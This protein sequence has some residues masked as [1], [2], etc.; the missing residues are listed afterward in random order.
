MRAADDDN[1]KKLMGL[2]K[3]NIDPNEDIWNQYYIAFFSNTALLGG[4]AADGKLN[5]Y[6]E[7]G[8]SGMRRLIREMRDQP[9]VELFNFL[10]KNKDFFES[11]PEQFPYNAI[12]IGVANKA[13]S[14]DSDAV[15]VVN[16]LS[17]LV[18]HLAGNNYFPFESIVLR[19]PSLDSENMSEVFTTIKN[20][21]ASLKN[22]PS[23]KKIKIAF[24][25][26]CRSHELTAAQY[27]EI[28]KII[29]ENN[30]ILSF[31]FLGIENTEQDAR[32]ERENARHVLLN[33]CSTNIRN[34]NIARRLA[35][36]NNQV[37]TEKKSKHG[38]NIAFLTSNSAGEIRAVKLGNA[39]K[40][41][42][43]DISTQA[44]Q[45]HQMQTQLQQE[46]QQ[47]TQ[48]QAQKQNEISADTGVDIAELV[49]RQRYIKFSERGPGSRFNELHMAKTFQCKKIDAGILG[50]VYGTAHYFSTLWGYITGNSGLENSF[51]YLTQ[52]AISKIH[53]MPQYF[54]GGLNFD[55]LPAGFFAQQ[56]NDGK[57][58]L[59][60][61]ATRNSEN[62]NKSPLTPEIKSRPQPEPWVGDWRQFSPAET[63]SEVYQNFNGLTDKNGTP[64]T[65]NMTKAKLYEMMDALNSTLSAEIK[66]N[67]AWVLD[68]RENR[69]DYRLSAW[70]DIVYRE[71]CEGLGS[72]LTVLK[73][74][75]EKNKD[76]ADDFIRAF[77]EFNLDYGDS[78]SGNFVADLITPENLALIEKLADLTDVQYR[79]WKQIVKCQS[80]AVG[81]LDFASL[82]KGFTYF[83]AQIPESV[84]LPYDCPIEGASPLVQLDRLLGILGKVNAHNL[85]YQ[86]DD[87][88]VRVVSIEQKNKLIIKIDKLKLSI[89]GFR[90]SQNSMFSMI[91]KSKLDIKHELIRELKLIR[92]LTENTPESE[93]ADSIDGLIESLK[94][95]STIIT[96]VVIGSIENT[97]NDLRVELGG[98]SIQSSLNLGPEG[99]WYAARWDNY[100]YFHPEMKLNAD[101]G[102]INFQVSYDN[103]REL[104]RS[105]E[106]SFSDIKTAFY[107]YIGQSD[108]I[109]MP[110]QKYID[111]TKTLNKLDLPLKFK[112]QLL[113]CLAIATTGPRGSK[114]FDPSVFFEFILKNMSESM[115]YSVNAIYKI[116][117]NLSERPTVN[118]LMALIK[119][120]SSFSNLSEIEN[121]VKCLSDAPISEK[122]LQ[123]WDLWQQNDNHFP[124]DSFVSLYSALKQFD[125]KQFDQL[126]R[127][128]AILK[129]S[130]DSKKIN[131]LTAELEKHKTK[132]YYEPL[133]KLIASLDIEKT[134]KD[135]LPT[136]D[137]LIGLL[138]SATNQNIETP[139]DLFQFVTAKLT[140]C[141]FDRASNDVEPLDGALLREHIAAFNTKLAEY[142]IPPISEEE[143]EKDG[144]TY[145]STLYVNLM[146]T[147]QRKMPIQFARNLA[148]SAIN[149]KALPAFTALFLA[150]LQI[151]T[152]QFS[153]LNKLKNIFPQ[154]AS[155][156][157]KPESMLD[158]LTAFQN[159]TASLEG[160]FST[161]ADLKKKWGEKFTLNRVINS[162]IQYP[163]KQLAEIFTALSKVNYDYIPTKLFNSIFPDKTVLPENT[164]LAE[165]ASHIEKIIVLDGLSIYQKSSLIDQVYKNPMNAN[166]IGDIVTCLQVLKEKNPEIQT[167]FFDT[168]LTVLS[169]DNAKDTVENTKSLLALFTEKNDP[170]ISI[171]FN[172]L[173]RSID[174][175]KTL[176]AALAEYTDAQMKFLKIMAYSFLR[177]ND[178]LKQETKEAYDDLIKKLKNLYDLTL[179]HARFINI[180]ALYDKIPRPGYHSLLKLIESEDFLENYELDPSGARL[181]PKNVAAQFNIDRIHERIDAIEDLGRDKKEGNA[182]ALFHNEREKLYDAIGYVTA[183]GKDS[184]ITIPGEL[185][186]KKNYQKPVMTLTGDEIKTL[187]KHYRSIISANHLTPKEI[188]TA[189]CEF[190]AL[191]REALYRTTGIMAYDTQIT[192]ILNIMLHGGSIFSEIRTGEGKSI[193]TA[194]MAAAKWAEGGVVDVASSNMALAKRDLEENKDF[195]DYLGIQTAVISASSS[196]SDY[197]QAGTKDREGNDN[198][199]GINYSDISEL[200]LWQEQQLLNSEKLPDKVSLI[201]DEVDFNVLDNTTQFR[202]AT[203]L[204]EAYDP[205]FN[206]YEKIY[207]AV[208]AFV[209]RKDLFL[210]QA[211]SAKQDI[212]NLKKY[213]LSEQCDL[214][215]PLKSKLVGIPELILD[216]WIN[217]AYVAT[218]LI[219]DEDYVIRQGKI[220]KNGEEVE[221]SEAQVRINGRANPQSRFSDGVQQFLNTLLNEKMK[222]DSSFSE[223]CKHNPFVIEPE[224]TYLASRSA[225]NT[226]DYYLRPDDKGKKRGDVVGLTGTLGT[227]KDRVELFKNYGVKFFRMPPHKTLRRVPMP[228]IVAKVGFGTTNTTE[229]MRMAHFNSIYSDIQRAQ[230]K[231]QCILIVCD[232]VEF[233]DA[234]HKFLQEKKL[235]KQKLQLHNGEQINQDE[236]TVT[237]N[238]AKS[239]M[240]TIS[241]LM[242]GRGTD[243]K[244]ENEN[245]LHVITTYISGEREYGQ[246]IGRAG[247]NGAKGSDQLIVSASEFTSRVKEIPSG[248]KKI[249]AE[250]KVIRDEI[251]KEKTAD[252]FERQLYSDVK[253]QF[254]KQYTD[255]SAEL[256]TKTNNPDD[257]KVAS[258]KSHI[259]WEAFLKSIDQ[260][261]NELLMG[262]RNEVRVE[263]AARQSTINGNMELSKTLRRHQLDALPKEMEAYEKT[264]LLEKIKA[265]TEFGNENWAPTVDDIIA[266]SNEKPVKIGVNGEIQTSS[267]SD[268]DTDLPLADGALTSSV[269]PVKAVLSDMTVIAQPLNM[270][271]SADTLAAPL[272]PS[273]DHPKACYSKF[274]GSLS[275]NVAK[276]DMKAGFKAF[277][278][279]LFQLKFPKNEMGGS[280][281]SF[282][283][284]LNY[285]AKLIVDDYANTKTF[286]KASDRQIAADELRVGINV[287]LNDNTDMTDENKLSALILLL[288]DTTKSLATSD[289]AADKSSFF[290]YR[291]QSGSRLQTAIDKVMSF[292]LS[293]KIDAFTLQD[294]HSN[295]IKALLKT[296]NSRLRML[297]MQ[298]NYALPLKPSMDD[299]RIMRDRLEK[300]IAY[301]EKYKGNQFWSDQIGACLHLMNST[302]KQVSMLCFAHDMGITDPVKREELN[303]QHA[304]QENAQLLASPIGKDFLDRHAV[305]VTKRAYEKITGFP[306]GITDQQKLLLQKTLLEIERMMT[307]KEGSMDFEFDKISSADSGKNITVIARFTEGGINKAL[308]IGIDNL[309]PGSEQVVCTA[310]KIFDGLTPNVRC[311]N[312]P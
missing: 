292:A 180:A 48:I 222:K 93:N 26:G 83:L 19:T 175:Y 196:N 27:N 40:L 288:Q 32:I 72:I 9:L 172:T 273:L 143:F 149:Q 59:C 299:L 7:A 16:S 109:A 308:R 53:A 267:S 202:Y 232:T 173:S 12:I 174:G 191:L 257:W 254:F 122:I 135:N 275:A 141:V 39:K 80:D 138:A 65:K 171:I 99:A 121:A 188:W 251:D 28:A 167:I 213:I 127:I 140:G 100:H 2:L 148:I 270:V 88:T 183:I 219:P 4:S 165:L 298:A 142:K 256:K 215:D 282:R 194:M 49:D 63:N 242:F 17:V 158:E 305:D 214:A 203:S 280:L 85:K 177:Q 89:S 61:D 82:Y 46:T 119:I 52:S 24:Q 198:D 212:I 249:N 224:K 108:C 221:T 193:I 268:S 11:Y 241:T 1:I 117:G 106:N 124:A 29:S 74:L 301:I 187:V 111:L 238:A 118:E 294:S 155:I 178:F 21:I 50:V 248:F 114:A 266:H 3:I 71:G 56:H 192:S 36:K 279:E 283:K 269:I 78:C 55:N 263:I 199:D 197:R 236:K 116:M 235:D 87:L 38:K 300:G 156:S 185:Q 223:K 261:W 286:W 306:S 69:F 245:G 137:D 43:F 23:V 147:L 303:L 105:D 189:K 6:A 233:S 20:I 92:V 67:H 157:G 304:L 311:S 295:N 277:E 57:Y 227:F 129:G 110:Y 276:A 144:A 96:D 244:P 229:S 98:L 290:R 134:G 30:L 44:E 76:I 42:A 260:K 145:L 60:Y 86:M 62:K 70:F 237:N 102:R 33:A 230:K 125:S 104:V 22:Y 107:R 73:N 239:G 226:L 18:T 91:G 54:L 90:D 271:I 58:V 285:A 154:P 184:K 84:T 126:S 66:K 113:C 132:S 250:I 296:I 97:L 79:W 131:A 272:Q 15:D 206:P 284:T 8:D 312:Q 103:L 120:T 243:I 160:L 51:H 190:I 41:L 225:K 35:K 112:K 205:H 309:Y 310:V 128:S 34:A 255:L 293:Q 13:N 77:I 181:E 75:H 259:R 152:K 123:S 253:D 161:L 234:L 258:Y 200:T 130:C 289:L 281:S 81:Y 291:N 169:S 166:L 217:S 228:P 136:I 133:L 264:Q 47:E 159:Y 252:R 274:T 246:N 139:N 208:L 220:S 163:P 151:H 68:T 31:D 153:D 10:I 25:N 115:E 231:G 204:D 45:Q 287:L 170:V 216:R 302:L 307:P 64:K 37:Q 195:Y 186:N 210:D 5:I 201:A 176:L 218:Q 168:M 95:D 164:D 101:D 182:I 247:R 209:Q 146:K 14:T 211:C 278:E 297:G 262:L 207:P 179:D 94:L 150:P 240:V 162:R 265:L